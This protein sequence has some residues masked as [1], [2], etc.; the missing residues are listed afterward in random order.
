MRN[1]LGRMESR[2]KGILA[3]AFIMALIASP[4]SGLAAEGKDNLIKIATAIRSL[5]GDFTQ[6]EYDERGRPL[7]VS[8]GEFKMTDKMQLWWEV[9]PPYKQTIISNGTHSMIYDHDLQQLIIR[10]LD[11]DNLPP[12]FFLANNPQ[13]LDTMEVAQPDASE[14]TFFLSDGAI[15]IFARFEK[16]VPV[17]ISWENQLNQRISIQ[18]KNLVR[19]RRIATRTFDFTP[20]EGTDIITD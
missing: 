5:Q 15:E 7:R 18:L 4:N 2:I 19:N 10:N 3:V 1:I 16:K 17:E 12:F 9:D 20:P 13:L 14:P 8:E 11:I 6:F